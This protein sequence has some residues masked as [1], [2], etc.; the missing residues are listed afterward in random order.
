MNR[1]LARPA[2]AALALVAACA[3]A[4]GTSGCLFLPAAIRAADAG[5]PSWWCGGASSATNACTDFSA[6]LDVV[7]PWAQQHLTPGAAAGAGGVVDPAIVVGDGVSYR[8]RPGTTFDPG[9]PQYL[10]YDGDRLAGLAYYQQSPEAPDGFA[11]SRDHWN[12]VGTSDAWVLPVWAIRPYE[13]QPDVFASVHPCLLPG[14]PFTSTAYACFLAS[15][16]QPLDVLVTNDDGVGAAGIDALVEGLYGVPGVAVTV[17]AP[18]TNQSGTGDTTTPGGAPGS[19]AN[20]ASGRAATSVAGTPADSV[21][22]AL[23]EQGV[24]PDLVI[25]GINL[26]QNMGPVNALSGTVGAARTAA[27]RGVPAIATSQG[28]ASTGAPLDFPSGVAATLALLED[29]RM[30]RAGEPFMRLPNL[31]IPSCQTGFANR[32]RL[33]VPTALAL[34]GR[35]YFLQDCTSTSTA[36]AD[37]IDAMNKGF[38]ALADA[39]L[40]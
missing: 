20:T 18:A 39:G 7:V 40:G 26:G 15:H 10:I 19:P 29:W 4:L 36:V 2:R 38:I 17:V 12:R 13:N 24:T 8:M 28:V 32:G 23:D 1:H 6:T 9:N 21:I 33:T 35:N 30:G 16:T 22:F 25:S 27:R 14:T 37:D 31:N 3:L 34:N 11:G 5:E